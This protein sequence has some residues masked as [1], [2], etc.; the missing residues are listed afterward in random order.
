MARTA[1][2]LA[3][4]AYR[5]LWLALLPVLAVRLWIKGG[6]YRRHWAERFWGTVP[7]ATRP[8]IWLH[9]VSVGETQAAYPLLRSWLDDTPE[10]QVLITHTTPTGRATGARLF[11][12]ELDTRV[13]QAYLP[14]DVPWAVRAFLQRARPT[15][16]LLMETELWPELLLQ[17]ERLGIPMVLVNGR[18]SERSAHQMQRLSWISTPALSRLRLIL[19]QADEHAA[20]FRAL[21][22][23]A[24]IRRTGSLKFDLAVS[25]DQ[26]AR[27]EAWRASGTQCTTR[28]HVVLL[29]SSRDDEEAEFFASWVANPPPST[30]LVVVPR[31][32]ERFDRVVDLAR[33][34]GLTV[35]RRSESDLGVGADV[36]VWV[37]D[38]LGE[39]QAYIAM[40]DL[41]VMGGSLLPLG[42]QNPIEACAQGRPVVFGPHMFNF[43]EIS[44][45]M[46]TVDAAKQVADAPA[47]VRVVHD[48]LGNEAERMRRGAL[49]RSYAEQHRGATERSLAALR[50]LGL[51]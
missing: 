35:G 45:Q 18:L 1:D 43:P 37:G 17:A 12:Q 16:G 15:V 19:A 3:H 10:G 30:L 9:A 38:S 24:T 46:L 40:S 50:E 27:G 2:P 13:F 26:V 7:Q 4:F 33:A 39:M 31:H 36:D 41:V 22:P 14:Y 5:L 47:A 21:S 48:W 23:T 25:A 20:R 28:K 6:A 42:G 32:P 51:L 29:A 8:L 11:A 34:S 49:A 44:R